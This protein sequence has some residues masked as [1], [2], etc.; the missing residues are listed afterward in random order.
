[1][2][3]QIYVLIDKTGG[4]NLIPRTPHG[5]R[6]ESVSISCP[7]TLTYIC[8]HMHLCFHKCMHTLTNTDTQ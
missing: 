1:M 5:K 2:V 4:L 3:Q 8:I 6:R 7:L